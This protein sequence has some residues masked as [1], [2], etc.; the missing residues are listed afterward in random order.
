MG[1]AGRAAE[2][3]GVVPRSDLPVAHVSPRAFVAARAVDLLR[4]SVDLLGFSPSK[5]SLERQDNRTDVAAPAWRGVR[6]P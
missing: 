4:A 5:A 6:S 1:P 2:Q 3:A